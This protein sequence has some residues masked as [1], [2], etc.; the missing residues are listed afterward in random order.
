[1]IGHDGILKIQLRLLRL[2][3]NRMKITG[4]LSEP[5]GAVEGP[6]NKVIIK[7]QNKDT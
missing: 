2:K 5:Q 6:P 4:T 7:G 1:M 3:M